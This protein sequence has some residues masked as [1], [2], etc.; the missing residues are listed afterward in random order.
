M[1]QG[2]TALAMPYEFIAVLRGQKVILDTHLAKLYGVPVKRLNQQVNRNRRRFPLGFIF[3]LSA[4]ESEDL[5]LQNATS[6]SKHGGRRY[7]PYAFTEHG[8]IM[9]ATVLNSPRAVKMSVFVVR[10]FVHFRQ[11]VVNN[12]ELAAKLN[13]IESRLKTYDGAIS[14]IIAALRELM[15]PKPSS[16]KRIGF[17][18]P[19]GKLGSPVQKRRLHLLN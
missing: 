10:A 12:S 13:E 18:L 3:Q 7:R 15:V 17:Q 2:S 9:A 4:K 16:G 14:E 6:S 11:L 1:K 8:A 19:P 5:R